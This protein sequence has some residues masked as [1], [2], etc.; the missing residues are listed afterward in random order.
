[1][2]LLLMLCM[3]IIRTLD[4]IVSGELMVL[5]KLMNHLEKSPNET[6]HKYHLAI[7]F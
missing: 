3:G 4:V 2:V 6:T 5:F 7:N 1:M